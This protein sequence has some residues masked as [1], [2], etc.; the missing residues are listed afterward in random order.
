YE[1]MKSEIFRLMEMDTEELAALQPTTVSQAL[2]KAL[3]QRA[4]GDDGEALRLLV[5]IITRDAGKRGRG[6]I[7]IV[8]GAGAQEAE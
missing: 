7:R 6:E 1:R 2:A 3:I 4:L 5:S 8:G